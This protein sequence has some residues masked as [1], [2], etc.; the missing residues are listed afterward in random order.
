VAKD[1]PQDLVLTPLLG[2]ARTV[3]EWLTMFHLLVIVLDPYTEESSWILG[4][5]TRIIKTFEQAD[6][7][8]AIVIASDDRDARQF[9]GPLAT[10]TLTFVDPE[11]EVIKALGLERLPAIVH[12]D[13]SGTVVGAAEGW[14][15]AEWRTVCN[16]L[17]K[18]M[19][20]SAP[21]LPAERD[22]GPFA[23]S[24]AA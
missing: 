6:C 24:P 9:L 13:L 11:R 16:R 23:G 4:P 8:V 2:K 12:I 14:N 10:E 15:P 22:P 7:R 1:P 20:W 17:A 18:V 19:A 21:S 5:A 3:S